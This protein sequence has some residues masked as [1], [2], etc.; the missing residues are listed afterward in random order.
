VALPLLAGL[1]WYLAANWG[2]RPPALQS[3]KNPVMDVLLISSV[4]YLT[5]MIVV[6]VYERVNVRLRT[7]RDEERQ[8]LAHFATHDELT[9]LAN[10]RYF[11]QRLEQACARS[12]RGGHSIA[13]LYIDLDGFKK[14]NDALGHRSGDVALKEIAGRLKAVLR[15]QDLV[16][17]LGGDEFAI[18]LDPAASRQEIDSFCAR[19]REVIARRLQLD[20]GRH[21][22]GASI[23]AV[24]YPGEVADVEH[25]LSHADAAM[26]REKH[27][28]RHPQV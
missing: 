13:V 19:L 14:I 7:E 3:H 9:G 15:R 22:V 1:Q 20:D 23:G 5:V 11:H 28:H 8:R 24:F 12:D 16:A 27:R 18:I 10:R 26:Y 21:T 2:W 17:R 6:L 4:N 25:L